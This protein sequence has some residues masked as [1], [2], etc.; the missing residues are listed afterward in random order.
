[1]DTGGL[2]Y[3]LG[4]SVPCTDKLRIHGGITCE[5]TFKD[6]VFAQNEKYIYSGELVTLD[7]TIFGCFGFQE[8]DAHWRPA[9]ELGPGR[10]STSEAEV[11]LGF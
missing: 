5:F 1:M 4:V 7:K 10:W 11:V 2:L 6:E 3:V 8:L 9:L